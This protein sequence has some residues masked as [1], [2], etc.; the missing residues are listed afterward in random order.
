VIDQF[1]KRHGFVSKK[2]EELQRHDQ[3][4]RRKCM[5]T[6]QEGSARSPARSQRR[7]APERDRGTPAAR[8]ARMSGRQNERLE[9]EYPKLSSQMP[10]P[11]LVPRKRP[12]LSTIGTPLST[13]TPNNRD[14]RTFEDSGLAGDED[15]RGRLTVESSGKRHKWIEDIVAVRLSPSY[16]SVS[17]LFISLLP[18]HTLIPSFTSF[19]PSL[20][21]STKFVRSSG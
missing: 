13:T 11:Q 19:R 3:T 14:R 6:T 21:A 8:V 10:P 2:E 5:R 4:P 1:L 16:T 7:Q 17:S 15:Q 9:E 18:R 20:E 12:A